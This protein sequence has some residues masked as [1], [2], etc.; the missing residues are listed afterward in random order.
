LG[1]PDDQAREADAF[2]RG[3]GALRRRERTVSELHEWLAERGFEA[4][5]IEVAIE[6]L[7]EL[8]ELDDER[9]ARRFAEDKRELS[10]WGPER[11][12]EVLLGRGVE[13]ELVEAAL[14]VD[15]PD[16]QIERAL[17][18]LRMRGDPLS[19]ERQR[20]KALSFLA[21]RG[22][23]LELAYEAVRRHG[24]DAGGDAGRKAA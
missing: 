14:A 19:D 16:Q 9:F 4:I 23:E 15:V 5:E 7:I 20:A 17:T 1:P 8:G 10:G 21:R 13:P 11:I 24:R 6:R 22:Y 3:L 12:R 18:L 2:T